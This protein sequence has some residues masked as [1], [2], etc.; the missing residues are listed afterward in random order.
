LVRFRQG[1]FVEAAAQ[2][3]EAIR[4]NPGYAGAHNNLGLVL[5]GQG[6]FVEAAAQYKKAIRLDPGDAMPHYNLGFV[7]FR[8]GNFAEAAAQYNQAIWL[9][10]NYGE[11]YNNLALLMAACPEAKYRDGGRAVES[12]TRACLLTEW[13]TSEFLNTLAAA[14]AECGDFDAA[15]RWQARALELLRDEREN[16]K[17]DYHSRLA[18]YQAKKPYR[19]ASSG[20]LPTETNP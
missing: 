17:G 6:K 10:P 12:A 13:K 18:L 16:E 8:Q 5:S 15:I 3:N 20:R 19:E 1:K 11:A 9:N 2:Y 14:Y 4:L 7:R